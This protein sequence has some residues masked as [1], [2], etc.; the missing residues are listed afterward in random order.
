[1]VKCLQKLNKKHCTPLDS[2]R[3]SIPPKKL[4]SSLFSFFFLFFS[5]F[6][7]FLF[8]FFISFFCC[9]FKIQILNTQ[10]IETPERHQGC[11]TL[12]YIRTKRY[13]LAE[14]GQCGTQTNEEKKCKKTMH[15]QNR[16]EHDVIKGFLNTLSLSHH[17]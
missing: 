4:F 7:C 10:L 12:E 16:L 8:L 2:L 17:S 5:L 6:S 3:L 14:C 15:C 13:V 9:F 1:M 11:N